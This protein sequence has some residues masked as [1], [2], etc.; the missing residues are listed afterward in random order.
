MNFSAKKAKRRRMNTTTT[1][2]EKANATLDAL[3]AVIKYTA[4]SG[5]NSITWTERMDTIT[6]DIIHSKLVTLGYKV[7]EEQK[8]FSLTRINTFKLTIKW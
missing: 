3:Y 8:T 1:Y 6:L 7:T 5:E 4:R 2:V